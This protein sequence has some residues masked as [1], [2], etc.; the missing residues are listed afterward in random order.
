MDRLTDRVLSRRRFF[1]VA[2]AL[3]LPGTLRAAPQPLDELPAAFA[4]LEKTNGGRL[5]VAVRDTAGGESTGYRADERFPMC[6]TFKFLL[7]AA[8]LQR[9]DGR[10]ETLEHSIGIPRQPLL[11]H[12]PLTGLH[13]GG[14]M[15][16]ADLCQ[17]ILT[18]SDNTAANLLLAT[19]GGPAGITSFSRSIGD[20]VTRLDRMELSLN[21]ARDGDPRDT[22]SP[23]AMAG[24]LEAVL[25]GKVLAPAARTQLTQWM[26]AC[27]TGLDRLRAKLP[28]GWRALDKTGSNGEHTSNDIAV[29]WP[30]G[31]APLIVT[32]YI[33]QCP[34]PDARRAGMLAD[35]GGLVMQ[36]LN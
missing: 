30:P 25:L 13:A 5:G 19:I 12:S 22:T 18:Q 20:H 23:A 9:V 17:A 34:G 27:L 32:A 21:E 15:T 16:V 3:A 2:A 11:S 7:A 10:R 26:A 6:S 4:R 36:S 8:V 1:T 14:S 28:A 31:R 29:F 33:T 35:I 24:D